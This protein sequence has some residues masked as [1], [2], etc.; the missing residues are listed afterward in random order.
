ML[1]LMLL[2]S[3]HLT[4]L[5]DVTLLSMTV[6]VDLSLVHPCGISVQLCI[7]LLRGWLLTFLLLENLM[8]MIILIKPRL[9]MLKLMLLNAVG[10]G[11]LL[12][13][14]LVNFS[15]LRLLRQLLEFCIKLL[16]GLPFMESVETCVLM[17][18]HALLC[19][20]M[21]LIIPR[22]GIL[23]Q[24]WRC[25]RQLIHGKLRVLLLHPRLHM[26]L[27]LTGLRDLRLL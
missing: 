25:T 7:V 16:I 18:M 27:L 24:G 17:P 1:N 13:R 19:C 23:L 8:S 3:K 11:M 21:L 5:R 14:A 12:C 10:D 6:T 9:P 4:G 20:T 2:D 22:V 26:M 15:R